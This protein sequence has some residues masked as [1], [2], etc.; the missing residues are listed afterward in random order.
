L[1]PDTLVAEDC[2][3]KCVETL[4]NN[5]TIGALGIHMID[6]SGQYLPESKRG[7]P[8]LSTSFYKISGLGKLF[9]KSAKFNRY[10]LGHLSEKND[11]DIDVLAGCYIMMPANLARKIGG[12]DEDYFMYGEDIDLSYQ[13][14]Q[15]GLKNKY[16]ADA[17]II[18][19]KGESTKKA[20]FNYL[21]L[22]YQ[23]MII[24]A[25]KNLGS[26]KQRFYVP[27][28]KLA[29]FF[30]A[31]LSMLQGVLSYLWMPIIDAGILLLSL[32][33]TKNLWVKYIK[34]DT[35]YELP[36]IATFFAV[37]IVIW[38]LSLTLTGA[39]DKPNRPVKIFKGIAIGTIITLAIYGLL[40]EAVRFS[41]GITI[42]G[43]TIGA[44]L[45]FSWR[46]LFQVLHWGNFTSQS[47]GHRI[48]I[49]G[50]ASNA[51]QVQQVLRKVGVEKDIVGYCAIT[52]DTNALGPFEDIATIAKLH[53]VAE[54]IFVQP[55]VTYKAMMDTMVSLKHQYNFKI[56]HGPSDSII[57]S[58]SKSTQGEL[59]AFDYHYQISMPQGKRDKRTFDIIA[60]LLLLVGS[61]LLYWM[62]KDKSVFTQTMS[63]L[64]GKNTWISYCPT[65]TKQ[66]LPKLKANFYGIHHQEKL[67]ETSAQLVNYNYARNYDWKQD[68]Q[69]LW[70]AIT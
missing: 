41:R 67:N 12:F 14:Q 57:G 60:A 59:Y 58:N 56:Y 62:V 3:A 8:D 4:N 34:T 15:H 46:K 42:G 48:L 64:A 2:L 16:I 28:I 17:K 31:T 5:A 47:E 55:D 37:Y 29:I 54:I 69:F 9:P 26:S 51:I 1:N 7:F 27:F 45:L 35:Q 24:F 21:K 43:A 25:Q 30:R 11:Q 50:E 65:T 66:N 52:K 49:A 36:L 40:P 70:K 13:V 32:W 19:F 68:A 20:T 18:H 6:G 33:Q 63:I 44:I 39:Y 53:K 38:L 23:A 61:P 10:Y 22:F